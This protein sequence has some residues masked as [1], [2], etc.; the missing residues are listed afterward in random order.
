MK[1]LILEREIIIAGAGL[2]GLLTSIMLSQHNIPVTTIEKQPLNLNSSLKSDGRVLAIT[3][4]GYNILNQYK[5][6]EGL[7]A[8][9]NPIERI[10]I[11]DQYSPTFLHFNNEDIGNEPLGFMV[12]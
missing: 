9:I 4:L 12:D 7:E 2:N 5:V 8:V 11:T 3:N 10:H 6:F 1:D